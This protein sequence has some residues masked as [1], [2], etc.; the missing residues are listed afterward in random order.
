MDAIAKHLFQKLRCFKYGMNTTTIK[1]MANASLYSI[2]KCP[3]GEDY[4]GP[5]CSIPGCVYKV[6]KNRKLDAFC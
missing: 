3:C 4:Y 1:S 5:Q 6:A 2:R